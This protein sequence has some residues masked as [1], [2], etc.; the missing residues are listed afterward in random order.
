[1]ATKRAQLLQEARGHGSS[2]PAPPGPTEAQLKEARA[3]NNGMNSFIRQGRAPASRSDQP[4]P[5]LAE[6]KLLDLFGG[7]KP[8]L[9]AAEQAQCLRLVS[10]EG[11]DGKGKLI[12]A[13][14]AVQ[15]IRVVRPKWR[16]ATGAGEPGAQNR[17]MNTA[18]RRLAGRG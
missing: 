12:P 16:P 6:P 17:A 8:K 5:Q 15:A 14:T 11:K 18:I 10:G 7:A 3:V 13:M 9:T 4:A 2:A 1:M